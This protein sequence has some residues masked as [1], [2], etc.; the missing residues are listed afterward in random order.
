MPRYPSPS[1]VSYTFGPGPL[2]P[3]IK[4]LVWINVGM[5]LVPLV[6]PEIT[7]YLALVPAAVIERLFIW[8]PLTYMFLH[9]GVF[10]ILFNMLMLWMFGTDLERAWGTRFF[11][12]YYAIAGVG[13]AAAT[14]LA[15]LVPSRLA[16]VLYLTPTVGASGA[17]YGLLV[18]YGLTFPNRPIYLYLLFPVPARVFVLIMG[19]IELLSSISGGGGNIAYS[20]HLGG[21]VVGYLYLKLRRGNLLGQ[22]NYRIAKARMNRARRRFDVHQGGRGND[23]NRWV[24]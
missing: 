22:I 23:A 20:A 5:F 18:A 4:A 8:Q 16:D 11:V 2:T 15:S 12:R 10:H 24:H 21:F 6:V 17:I 14:V 13:A 1:R 7:W 19:A 3:A 9:A